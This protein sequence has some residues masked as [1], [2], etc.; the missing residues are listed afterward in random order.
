MARAKSNIQGQL[1]ESTN[2][3]NIPLEGAGINTGSS[4]GEDVV[5]KLCLTNIDGINIV[6][7]IFEHG[8][9]RLSNN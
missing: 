1:T 8:I 9:L 3:E 6:G 4:C 2:G 7:S 5:V